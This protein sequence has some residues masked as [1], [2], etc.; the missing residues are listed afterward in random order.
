MSLFQQL[1]HCI[2]FDQAKK[3]ELK[4]SIE[5][6]NDFFQKF[7]RSRM[8]LA[9]SLFAE[10]MKKALFEIIYFL[11]VNDEKY[12]EHKYITTRIEK[13]H[14][15]L[16][17][18]EF[19]ATVPLYLENA[20]SGVV[21]ISN[22]SPVFQ[23]QFKQ[24]IKEELDATIEE[25]SGFSPIYSIASLGSIGTI[26]HKETA[27][28]L[29]L[30]V[31]Y[32][33]VP[34]L[35]DVNKL[36]DDKLKECSDRLIDLFSK[37]YRLKKKFTN[38]AVKNPQI[39][40]QILRAGQ[41]NFKKRFPLL[42]DVIVLN[43]KALV[44]TV[45]NKAELR[46]KMAIEVLKMVNL[47]SKV[48]LKKEKTERDQLLKE[49]IR[50]IQ[51][52]IQ[53]KYPK[54]EV[55]LF[56][57]S[58]DD[59]RDGLHGTTLESKEASGSAYQLILN[60]EVLM[61]GI[62]FTP[63][64]PIHFLMSD[65]INGKRSK[66][67]EIVE[68][69]RY[70]FTNLFEQQRFQLVD[71]GSTP[72]LTL[73]YMAAHSGAVYW[74]SFKASSGN[75][76]KATL[77]LLRLEMLFDSRFNVSLIELIK[78]PRKLD[79]FSGEYYVPADANGNGE[80]DAKEDIDEWKI[81]HFYDDYG[82]V[83]S[84][85]TTDDDDDVLGEEDFPGGLSL[86]GV[87]D[88]ESEFHKLKE[89]P[90]WLRYKAL[91][92]GFGPENKDIRDSKEKDLIS[93]VIDLGFALH[94]RVS[95]VF[96]KIKN[97]QKLEVYRDKVLGLFLVKA[98]PRSKRT[99]LENICNGEVDSVIAFEK[100]LRFLFQRSMDRVLSKVK[101]SGFK[102]QTNEN[103]NRIWY[104]YYQQNFIQPKNTIQKDIL[105]HLKVPRGRLQIGVN[106]KRRWFFRS[107]QKSILTE[108]QYDTFGNLAHL[109][110]KVDLFEHSSFLHGI[111]HCIANGYYGIIN[112]GTLLESRTYLEFSVGHTETGKASS[113]KW[114]FMRPDIADRLVDNINNAF[115]PQDYD[116]RDCIFKD[117]EI[118]HVFICLNLLE[119]GRVSFMYR[120]NLKTWYV[121][122]VSHPSVEKKAQEMF[123]NP[124]LLFESKYIVMTIRKFFND[125]KITINEKTKGRIAFW[126]NPNSV[127][128]H[129][130]ADRFAQKEQEL[131]TRFRQ[132]VFNEEAE[133]LVS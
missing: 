125:N 41:M 44:K 66:Y 52:Y 56:A 72:P 36:D 80:G 84:E 91:K 18:V 73:E 64:I 69:I 87:F 67:E 63:V 110:D 113:D 27:S 38:E 124:D 8:E 59:Y 4:D 48:C 47:F 22:L 75:L 61:P 123:Q 62:Q 14:G 37:K 92:I 120:D 51:I 130:H 40:S 88:I 71:L 49:K 45:L 23:S 24:F 46:R 114:A 78:N 82:I 85:E 76:P 112:K 104:H 10:D 100:E 54:A 43:K 133:E 5:K 19:E 132:L 74:E 33:L 129:H 118:E 98:F 105:S 58:N 6:G 16:K 7:N 3:K 86:D 128:T 103:E 32:E 121:D 81:D 57:Y 1:K 115:P 25:K 108:S 20:P 9:F 94:I 35:I 119:Y 101:E 60:Y 13:V 93:R 99:Y 116:F 95:D 131:S 83:E 107:I 55:Y 126:I 102:D 50:R 2:E 89:D 53:K 96:P 79:P 29:D 15:A 117:K 21:G 127:R 111:A 90:W 12:E 77:N 65:S 42:F 68:Y 28:D 70:N 26:G 97:K 31:Q 109:P 122:E 106:D 30:Q 34:F 17:E 11:H 39:R